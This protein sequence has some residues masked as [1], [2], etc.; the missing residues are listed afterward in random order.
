[1]SF[2]GNFR[3]TT[4][5]SARGNSRRHI[6]A[7]D[8]VRQSKLE[9]EE[10]KKAKLRDGKAILIQVFLYSGYIPSA[11]LGVA[12]CS[13]RPIMLNRIWRSAAQ[14]HLPQSYERLLNGGRALTKLRKICINSFHEFFRDM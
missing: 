11:L 4:K 12:V 6:S 14:E 8:T 9:R 3:N 5:F 13:T 10:R 2:S 1:M 7:E